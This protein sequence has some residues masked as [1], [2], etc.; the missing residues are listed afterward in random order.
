MVQLGMSETVNIEWKQ[1]EIE[2]VAVVAK[3]E[4]RESENASHG[5]KFKFLN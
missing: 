2:V 4:D 3:E 5:L 1:E